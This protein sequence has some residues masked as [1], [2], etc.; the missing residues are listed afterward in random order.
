MSKRKEIT[1]Y[2]AHPRPV[3]A[4]SILILSILFNAYVWTLQVATSKISENLL[5]NYHMNFSQMTYAI[6]FYFYAFFL[7]QI[8]VGILIDRFG[9]RKIPTLAILVFAVGTFIFSQSESYIIVGLSRFLM[10]LG[11]SFAFLNGLKLVSNWFYT[12]RFAFMVGVFVGLSS[13]AIVLM[14]G[15][16]SHLQAVIGWRPAILVFSLIGLIIGCVFFFVVKDAPEAGFSV[17][18]GQ[19][20]GSF[21]FFLKK[22]FRNS[23]NWINGITIGFVIAPL[24]AFL[25]FWSAP[26]LQTNYKIPEATAQLLSMFCILGYAIGVP[27]FARISTSIQRR[28]IFIPWGA[29]I[30][31]LML[32]IIIYPP[33]LSA[34]ILAVCYFILGFSASTIYLSFVIVHEC[35]LPRMAGTSFGIANMFFAAFFAMSHLLIIFFFEFGLGT[36]HESLYSIKDF[37]VSLLRIPIYLFI[38]LI[39]SL[40]I[41]ETRCKQI[42]SYG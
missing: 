11:G 25:S 34:Q 38:G 15:A 17:H 41:K 40:F 22:V 30:A 1:D 32:L 5:V 31:I 33:Y 24:F 29:G 39:F 2:L 27:F 19:Q 14:E 36:K 16:I 10:G 7:M 12:K 4:W 13:L 42:Y 8:P 6:G 28:K 9:P 18:T 21:L 37:E 3:L 26:F 35:N 20:E 23:Q